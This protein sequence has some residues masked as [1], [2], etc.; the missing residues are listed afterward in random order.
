[1]PFW[2]P[3][4]HSGK[5]S[6]CNAGDAS[7]IPGSGRS[8]EE[9]NGNRLQYSC[10]GNPMDRGAWQATVHR[11]TRV[12][13][14]LATKPPPLFQHIVGCK[15][16]YCALGRLCR[17]G[18][19]REPHTPPAPEQDR[20]EEPCSLTGTPDVKYLF[21]RPDPSTRSKDNL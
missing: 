12:G 3:R 15:G 21:N 16:F 1:M 8:P 19:T 14:N 11:V 20:T 7:L 2:L 18:G 10:L 6:P 4:W 13:C 5:E 17:S 9:G